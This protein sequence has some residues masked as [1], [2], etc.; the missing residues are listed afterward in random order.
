MY[1]KI[2]SL[3]IIA[4]F[5]F[6]VR[7]ESHY[8]LKKEQ[9]IEEAFWKR[10][11]EANSVRKKSI[12]D[13]DYI[14]IP[15]SL[16]FDAYDD[17]INI[18]DIINTVKRLQNEKVVNLSGYTNT[19]LKYMY[20]TANITPLS[21]YDENYTILVTALQKWADILLKNGYEAEAIGIMEFMVSTKSDISK[22][23]RI[24]GE[25]YKNHSMDDKFE[26]LVE[27]AK[28]IKSAAGNHIVSDLLDY[29]I[30][31]DDFNI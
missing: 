5:M 13:L 19:D 29:A 30:N 16:P 10:E 31:R 18:P 3:L 8:R 28:E 20:G 17:G 9:D 12:E 6:W 14:K 4:I 23:Y 21:E 2:A 15:D 22:T 25:Y 26:L 24:L 1:W 27:S 11:R 7:Y